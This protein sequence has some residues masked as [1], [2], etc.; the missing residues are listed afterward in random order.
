MPQVITNNT[1]FSTENKVFLKMLCKQK[2]VMS[3]P[4]G[5]ILAFH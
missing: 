3:S 5:Y 4:P 1:T 2:D